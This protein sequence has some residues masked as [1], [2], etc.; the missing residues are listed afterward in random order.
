MSCPVY[1]EREGNGYVIRCRDC[2]FRRWTGAYRE[3][4]N[5]VC[6]KNLAATDKNDCPYLGPPFANESGDGNAEV[7]VPCGCGGNANKER[8]ATVFEC[9]LFRDADGD[10]GECLPYWRPSDKQREKY[11]GRLD[12]IRLCDGCGRGLL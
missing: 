5:Y 4:V 2:D 7:M 1:C 3:R 12:A 6:P 8:P 10:P 9:K 11:K